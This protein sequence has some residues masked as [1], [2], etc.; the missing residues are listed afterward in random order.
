VLSGCPATHSG[1]ITNDSSRYGRRGDLHPTNLYQF[2]GRVGQEVALEVSGARFDPFLYLISPSGRLVTTGTDNDGSGTARARAVLT[3]AGM[4][5]VEVAPFTPFGR[6][7][8][9]LKVEGCTQP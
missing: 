8:Y 6:G 4:W 1:E 2:P 5:G 7:S 9:T 3:E